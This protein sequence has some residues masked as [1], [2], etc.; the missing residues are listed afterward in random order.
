M[1]LSEGDFSTWKAIQKDLLKKKNAEKETLNKLKSTLKKSKDFRE[2]SFI[3]I[4][5]RLNHGES[6]SFMFT[7]EEK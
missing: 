1:L 3:K 5:Q 7:A 2:M 6:L 4:K